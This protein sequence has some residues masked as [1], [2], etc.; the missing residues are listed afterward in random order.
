MKLHDYY[1]FLVIHTEL[2]ND[3]EI[4]YSFQ[5][6]LEKALVYLVKAISM[7]KDNSR[8][9]FLVFNASVIYWQFSRPFLKPK[10]RQYLAPSLHQVVKALDDIE[11][12]DYEWRAQLMM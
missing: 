1:I 5:E 6:Q 2:P 12:K 9:H 8:Y 11:D 7:A 3:F 4:L 10:Y